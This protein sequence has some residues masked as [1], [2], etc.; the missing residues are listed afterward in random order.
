MVT[1][2]QAYRF[3]LDPTVG[4]LAALRSHCGGQRYAFNWGLARIKANLDQRAAEKSYDLPADQLTPS[5]SW[6]AYSLR[7]TWNQAKDEVA[8]WWGENSKEAYSSGLANLATALT[9][10][11]GSRAGERRGPA[12]RFPR[13]KGKRG[14]VSCR[15]TTGAFGLAEA[16]RRHVTL[17]RIGTVRTCESTRKLAR[18]VERGTARIRSATVS[19]RSGRW[20]CS[21]SVE[22]TRTDPAP[23]RPD[24]AVGVDLGVTALAVLSTGEVVPNPRH[25]DV[26]QQEL[27]RLQRQAAR[28]TGPDR[29]T[30]QTPSNRWRK[31]QA[32][33][34][35][36]HTTIASARRD[37]LHKLTTRLTSTYGAIVLEDLN[38]AGMMRNHRLA[39]HVAGVGMGELRRQTTYKTTWAG[40]RLIVAD[41]WYPSSKTCSDCGAV[42]A[43]LPLRVRVYHCDE[44]GLVLD[45]DLNAARN[46]AALVGE[47]AACT[48]TASCAGT[49]NTPDG[50]PC[51]KL[52]SAVQA[53]RGWEDGVGRSVSRWICDA[54]RARMSEWRWRSVPGLR[55][56]PVRRVTAAGARVSV[57]LLPMTSPGGPPRRT[58][59]AGGER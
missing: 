11:Q 39:R 44:C 1:V 4:Q 47:T 36:L 30:R 15:F 54:V 24:T 38:V 32:R 56:V 52:P 5:V 43:K 40:G 12:V 10:W 7:K 29:R 9:N 27:R 16:D 48:S 2:I 37:G 22:I 50:N 25:L 31:T 53:S 26:A 19:W 46:L 8:P 34:A 42:K 35:K 20:F 55:F 41:R 14:G 6:S 58:G 13:F 21:F 18:H 51:Q 59:L 3:A 57:S 49:L 17:P 45:R 33:I 23:A 28:R